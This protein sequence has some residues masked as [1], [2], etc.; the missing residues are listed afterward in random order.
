M[1]TLLFVAKSMEDKTTVAM[2]ELRREKLMRQ[3]RRGDVDDAAAAAKFL[4]PQKAETVRA[5]AEAA[6]VDA[7]LRTLK[8]KRTAKKDVALALALA[9]KAN[10]LLPLPPPPLPPD[11]GGSVDPAAS[12]AG[13][14]APAS[15]P[16]ASG[17]SVAA[18]ASD[19]AASGAG[20]AASASDAGVVAPKSKAPVSAAPKEV[21]PL[22]PGSSVFAVQVDT[23]ARCEQTLTRLAAAWAHEHKKP[24]TRWSANMIARECAKYRKGTLVPNLSRYFK[25]EERPASKGKGHFGVVR[26]QEAREVQHRA[27]QHFF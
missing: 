15:A 2:L 4:S 24:T 27:A 16:A 18:P 20:V 12:G 22:P 8:D 26:H 1:E 25:G 7:E 17:A 10:T 5:Q 6:R 19:L 23:P 11:S 9:K 13:V 21:K 3:L 14:A